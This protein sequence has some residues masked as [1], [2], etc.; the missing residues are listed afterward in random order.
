MT[1]FSNAGEFI[2][3]LKIHILYRVQD[4]SA[5]RAAPEMMDSSRSSREGLVLTSLY[6]NGSITILSCNEKVEFIT[7][8]YD[9]EE[10]LWT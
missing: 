4:E 1:K 7:K 8:Q 5:I 10:N 6:C 2:Y 9:V 3:D